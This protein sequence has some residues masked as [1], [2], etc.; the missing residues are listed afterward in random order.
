MELQGAEVLLRRLAV[1]RPALRVDMLGGYRFG[2]LVDR[3]TAHQ[4]STSLDAL[5]GYDP[6]TILDRIDVFKSTND[7]HGGEAGFAARWTRGCWSVE[8]LGKVG[9]GA[10]WTRVVVKGATTTTLGNSTLTYLGGLLALPSNIGYYCQREV[11]LLSELGVSL[12]C[13]VTCDLSVSVGFDLL[14][15]SRVGRAADQ[16]DL[17]LDP[18]QIPPGLWTGETQPGLALDTSEFW[19]QGLHVSVEHQ[20]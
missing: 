14:H 6:G 10:T 11:T 12:R 9:L 8:L 7:F 2:R 16:I 13:Q 18:G 19:A 5:S 15:W 1:C 4:Q 20:F 3:L 17:C